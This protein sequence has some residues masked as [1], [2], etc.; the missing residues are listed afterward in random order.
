MSKGS[1]PIVPLASISPMIRYFG[2]RCASLS[3]CDSDPLYVFF[4]C[5]RHTA[6]NTTNAGKLHSGPPITG[7]LGCC[8]RPRKHEY[9]KTYYWSLILECYFCGN[10]QNFWVIFISEGA[11]QSRV[12][13]GEIEELCCFPP[14]IN[15][16]FQISPS[17][18][19]GC[20]GRSQSLTSRADLVDLYE[21]EHFWR[22]ALICVVRSFWQHRGNIT[23]CD[24]LICG[25][26]RFIH[27]YLYW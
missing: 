5:M 27:F 15:D 1:E 9:N 22:V 25:T 6:C 26:F 4:I 3:K 18:R 16:I 23:R 2:C 17:F 14:I 7:T 19:T 24:V 10:I 20:S 21:S 11:G 8:V 13:G 12:W